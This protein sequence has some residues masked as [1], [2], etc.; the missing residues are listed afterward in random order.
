M[1]CS[2]KAGVAC[3]CLDGDTLI[4]RSSKLV[5]VGELLVETKNRGVK[6]T[7]NQ[8]PRVTILD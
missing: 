3:C 6:Q 5:G 2:I 8:T 1:K 7:D 4:V